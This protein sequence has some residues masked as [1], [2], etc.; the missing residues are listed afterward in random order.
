MTKVP[1]FLTRYYPKR[2]DLFVARIMATIKPQKVDTGYGIRLRS[3]K[4]NMDFHCFLGGNHLD[5]ISHYLVGR[6]QTVNIE[7][8]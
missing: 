2:E 3:E 7:T 8:R 6:Y 1:D 5:M 4:R